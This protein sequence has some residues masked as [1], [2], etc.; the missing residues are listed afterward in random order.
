MYLLLWEVLDSKIGNVQ[1][2]H[3]LR[4]PVVWSGPKIPN[5]LCLVQSIKLP[6]IIHMFAHQLFL[7]NLKVFCYSVE[8]FKSFIICIYSQGRML[9]RQNGCSWGGL[10]SS[11]HVAWPDRSLLH[12]Q[13]NH[14]LSFR[15]DKLGNGRLHQSM[16]IE[17]KVQC[18][19][20]L[21]IK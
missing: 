1:S 14:Y 2:W 6:P 4:G 9:F 20:S 10:S 12:W 13:K 5:V 18:Y 17:Q 7:C 11:F 16:L 21:L 19:N 3:R 8:L 15:G